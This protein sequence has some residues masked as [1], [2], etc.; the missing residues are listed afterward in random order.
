[1]VLVP[2]KEKAPAVAALVEP[3]GEIPDQPAEFPVGD[4]FVEGPV[5]LVLLRSS[6]G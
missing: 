6:G 3:A 4:P 1:M 5:L 2:V